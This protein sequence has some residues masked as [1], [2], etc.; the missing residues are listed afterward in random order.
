MKLDVDIRTTASATITVEISDKTLEEI[1]TNLNVSVDKLTVDDLVDV[2][3]E[4]MNT[5]QICAQCTGW[6]TDWSLE[7]GD[8][9]EID[10]DPSAKN[11]E[12]RGIRVTER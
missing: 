7:L 6:N 3:Y 1:A 11:P 12:Y 5:P 9:W 10:D 8:E 4:K 2:I